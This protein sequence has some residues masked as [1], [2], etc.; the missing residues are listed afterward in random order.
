M[1]INPPEATLLVELPYTAM[2]TPKGY[3]TAC[4]GTAQVVSVAA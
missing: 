4:K 1:I 3:M 2:H